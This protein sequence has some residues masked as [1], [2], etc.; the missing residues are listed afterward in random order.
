MHVYMGTK[1]IQHDVLVKAY[2]Y[3]LMLLYYVKSKIIIKPGS[4]LISQL[5]KQTQRRT[6]YHTKFCFEKSTEHEWNG[7]AIT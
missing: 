7:T 1:C 3:S 5:C 2:A 6:G 4:S